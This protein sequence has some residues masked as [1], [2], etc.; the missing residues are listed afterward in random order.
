MINR[1]LNIVCRLVFVMA[2]IV[3]GCKQTYKSDMLAYGPDVNE[4][5]VTDDYTPRAIGAT[6]GYQPWMEAIK[7]EFDCVVT[8]YNPDSS[9]YLTEQ[10][11]EIYP[12]SNSIRISAA[13]PQGRFVWLLSE[14]R[15]TVPEGT[16]QF[17]ALP[18]LVDS[19]CFA[20]AILDMTTAPVRFLD[21][22]VKFSKL[23]GPVKLEGLW[24]YPIEQAGTDEIEKPLYKV[25]FYLNNAT[26]LVD[27]IWFVSVEGQKSLAVRGYDYRKVE[28]RQVLVPTKM[29][30]FRIDD[31]GVLQ[32][33]LVKIDFE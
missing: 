32:Q 29:E 4:I 28:E 26:S 20:E 18:P 16:E 11:Y 5:V 7:L 14:G 22:S 1:L 21:K 31:K 17:C 30:I 10:H 33:R 27:M 25:V 8:F 2:F 12:W 23:P 6:G 9:F 3:A 13:E 19:R 15:F 24:Y